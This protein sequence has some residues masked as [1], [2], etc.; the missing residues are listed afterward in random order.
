MRIIRGA[1][2]ARRTVLRR[3]PMG[4]TALPPAARERIREVFGAE[5]SAQEVVERVLA[6]VR[7]EGDAA[8]RRYGRALDGVEYASL[9]VPRA[10][11]EAAHREVEPWPT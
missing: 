11:I 10:E 9:E 2:E 5:L 7:A 3:Q 1:E 4:Q 8:V 6:D